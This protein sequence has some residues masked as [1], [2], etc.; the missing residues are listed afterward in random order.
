[1]INIWIY[2]GEQ[3]QSPESLVL[4]ADFITLGIVETHES[5]T[6]NFHFTAQADKN[7]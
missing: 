3:L 6:Q 1:M 7:S 2:G 5:L 4:S